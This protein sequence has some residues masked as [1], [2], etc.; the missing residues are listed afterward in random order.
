MDLIQRNSFSETY[1]I[2]LPFPFG[3]R[4]SNPGI[5]VSAV[6]VEWN[7][8]PANELPSAIIDSVYDTVHLE[9]ILS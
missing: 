6:F 4:H 9:H 3:K 5:D 7:T 8:V 1:I 2:Y